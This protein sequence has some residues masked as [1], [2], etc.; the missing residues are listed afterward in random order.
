MRAFYG[1]ARLL[2]V[3][4]SLV[5]IPLGAQTPAP[6]ADFGAAALRS[7]LLRLKTTASFLQVT[8][9][10]DDEDGGLLTLLS[11]TRGVRTGLISL[12]RGEGGQNK[13][14][15]ELFDELGVTRTEE[16]LASGRFYGIE[17]FFTRAVD[18]GFSKTL[19]E[20]LQKWRFGDP[21][22]G[23]VVADLVRAIRTFRP[24]VLAARFS[25]TDRDGHAHHQASAILARRAFAEAGDP[26][27]FREQL[28]PPEN[29]S[30]WSPR[31]L[32]IGILRPDED[33]TVTEDVGRFDPLLSESPAELAWEGLSHQRTQGVGQVRPDPGPRP[34]YYKRIDGTPA[35]AVEETSGKV[36]NPFG[37]GAGTRRENGFFDGI[38][39]S[40]SPELTAIVDEA[41]SRFDALAPERCTP[42]LARGLARVRELSSKAAGPARDLLLI[43]ERQFRDALA[44]SLSLDLEAQVEPEKPPGSPFPGFR[45]AVETLRVAVPGESF[46]VSARLLPRGNRA[47]EVRR[48][49]LEAPPGWTI[50]ETSPG[51]FRVTV[52]ASPN[53]SAPRGSR[54]SVDDSI[55]LF[56]DPRDILS[57]LPPF[58]LRARATYEIDG[59]ESFVEAVVATRTIDPLRGEQRRELAVLPAVSVRAEPSLAIVPRNG[60]RHPLSIEVEVS[61]ND[62]GKRAG[63]VALSA[64]AGWASSA[65]QP[66]SLA[67]EKDSQKVS[68]SVSPPAGIAEGEYRVAASAQD[69]GRFDR[70]VEFLE[71]PDIGPYCFLRPAQTRVR[72]VDLVL[73]PRLKVGYVVGAEDTIVDVLAQLDVDLHLLTAEE[74]ARGDLRAYSV[75][76]TGPRAYDV[77]AD[78]RRANGRLLDYVR[79]GGRLVV[80]YNSN[81]RAFSAGGYFPYP[82]KFG[83]SNLRVTVEDSPVEM[84][85]PSHP[86]WNTP[87]RI[88]P[89][90]F[91]GWVQERGLYFPAEW[92]PEYTPLVAM[93]DPGTE[94]LRGGLLVAKLG[95][96]T[97]VFTGISF[98]RELPRGVPGAIRLFANLISPEGLPSHA[99]ALTRPPAVPAGGRP[100]PVGEGR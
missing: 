6:P 99:A 65:A 48:I 45:F 89:K 78:L 75:I 64:P 84:L 35:A 88:T 14:G 92:G 69:R 98:F 71:H 63:L 93:H 27:K 12:T 34:V 7:G 57:P 49:E 32:Y 9:H 2:F 60:A 13:I 61:S 96:G 25:G 4:A 29:L 79:Q 82:A 15:P 54:G 21:D 18:Y 50:A 70:T 44:A 10:P 20:A 76:V 22:G 24:D 46:D 8:A 56:E 95:K 83:D 74:L 42:A 59:V 17:L 5:G 66:F 68:F 47:V 81:T 73:P 72:V 58:P 53:Y 85:S 97:Y 91:E 94:T 23:P 40:L 1:A 43:K 33:W 90:D 38:D 77:R 67:R 100:L 52:A 87:N 26:T 19:A 62:V 55:A 80:Q 31:K 3:A 36:V 51:R 28:A 86:I 41:L 16:L 11:R 39:V 37:P 30:P